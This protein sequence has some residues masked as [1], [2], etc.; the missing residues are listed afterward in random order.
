MKE[1]DDDWKGWIEHNVSNGCD[2]DEMFRIML[3]AGF[4]HEHISEAMSYEP[5]WSNPALVSVH[6]AAIERGV[7]FI[8]NAH[9]LNS[10][11]LELYVVEDFLSEE[12][13]AQLVESIRQSLRPSTI[14]NENEPDH[15]YRTSHTSD[16]DASDPKI[17]ILNERICKFLGIDPSYAESIQGQDYLVGQEFKIHPDYFSAD[18]LVHHSRGMGQRTYTMMIYLND[19]TEGGETEFPRVGLNISP[20][21]GRALIW[22][23]LKEDGSPNPYSHH[24]A[25]P[26]RDGRKTVVTKW[27]RS[28]SPVRPMPPMFTKEANELIPNCTFRGFA[29]AAVPDELFARLVSFYHTN[30]EKM[31]AETVPGGYVHMAGSDAPCSSLVQLSDE[32]RRNVHEA[33]RPILERWCG[34]RLEPTHVYGIRVYHGGAVLESHRDRY[35]THTI[36]AILNVAQDADE[37][38][39]LIIEDNYYRLYRVLLKPGELILYEGARLRHGRPLPFLGRSF[40]NVFCHYKLAGQE[41]EA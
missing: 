28:Y 4:A 31:E 8:P 38:W 9:C 7:L 36:S 21:R 20:R 35:G 25:K 13:C 17:A 33:L 30:R 14:T 18:S 39:P 10:E 1:V 26:V 27:F 19:V 23:N 41:S 12:E 5:S 24:R 37:D 6:G 11:L 32:L 29:T 34:R 2:K 22:N 40:A 3:D 15:Y 16:L